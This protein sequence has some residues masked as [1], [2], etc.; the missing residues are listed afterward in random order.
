MLFLNKSLGKYW[1]STYQP[2]YDLK[3]CLLIQAYAIIQ[4]GVKSSP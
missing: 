4:D 1:F 3:S 2:D